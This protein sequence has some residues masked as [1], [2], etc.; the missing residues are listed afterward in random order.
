MILCCLGTVIFHLKE[1]FTA[2]TGE[3]Q[4]LQIKTFL[5]TLQHFFFSLY[6]NLIIS[7]INVISIFQVVC[8]PMCQEPIFLVR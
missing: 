3:L 7:Y 2:G 5:F 4:V 1:S 8:S 6:P